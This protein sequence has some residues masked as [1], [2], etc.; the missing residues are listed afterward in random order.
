MIS[1]ATPI[2]RQ[3]ASLRLVLLAVFAVAFVPQAL[4]PVSVAYADAAFCASP[5]RDGTAPTSGIVNAYY[6]PLNLGS[7]SAGTTSIALGTKRPV[8]APN[9]APGDLVIVMQMQ[10]ATFDSTNT[11]AY[12]DGVVLGEASGYTGTPTAGRYE[13]LVAGPATTATSLDL[14]G[15]TLVNTYTQAVPTASQGHQRYQ[16]VRVPQYS[17][18]TLAVAGIDVEDWNGSTGGVLAIDVAGELNFNGARI[19]AEEA[20][21]RG[22]GALQDGHEA[23]EAFVRAGAS[24]DGSKGEG[25]AGTPQFVW[26]LASGSRIDT[27][28]DGYPGGSDARGAP[29]NAGGGGSWIASGG[30]GGGNGGAGGVGG[31]H[32][33]NVTG[34]VNV[35]PSGFGGS[36]IPGTAANIIMGGGGGAGTN[37]DPVPDARASGG[38]GGG[39]VIVR[40]GSV[41][42]TGVIDVNG[43]D[44]FDN[45]SIDPGGGGGAG[46]TVVLTAVSSAGLAN[47][48][49]LA[50]GGDGGDAALLAINDPHGPGGGAA[51]GRVY[52]N[53]ALNAASAVAGGIAGNTQLNGGGFGPNGAT[54]GTAGTIVTNLT[55]ADLPNSVSGAACLPVLTVAKT[56]ST[57]L[58]NLGA[59]AATYAITVSNAAGRGAASAVRLTDPLPAGFTYASGATA[60][61]AGG[62]TGPAAPTNTGSA[63][64]PAFGDFSIPGG[65]SV[66]IGFSV[67]IDASVGAGTYQNPATVTYTDPTRNDPADRATPGS[68]NATG[69]GTTGGSNY[70]SSSSPGEDVTLRPNGQVRGRVFFDLDVNGLRGPAEPLLGGVTITLRDGNGTIIATTTTAADG[71]YLFTSVPPGTF[72]VVV[73]QTD[74]DIPRDTRITAGA[75]NQTVTVVGSSIVQSPDVGFGLTP[76]AVTLAHFGAVRWS[77]G[78]VLVNWV[79]GAERDTYG[80]RV[81]RGTTGDRANA[82][83]VSPL[84]AARGGSGASYQWRDT[85]AGSAAYVYWIEEI[86]VGGTTTVYGPTRVGTAA[87]VRPRIFLPVAI[88]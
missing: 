21:S 65:A 60:T 25:I 55:P 31:T 43:T 73:D 64:V 16:I 59:T 26:S 22:G 54:P 38:A 14:T 86:E 62:A 10:G 75:A 83:A 88:R 81:L 77:D 84:V 12:G 50:T 27:G 23:S 44:G 45:P 34:G 15:T 76:L 33:F 13:Y 5:G 61:F 49:V 8:S 87:A 35:N 18:L 24:Q 72:S 48:T 42:G 66:T 41:A 28:V 36:V 11:A 32:N 71:S 67:A 52:A 78:V 19:N 79:T 82:V 20:G 80:F 63:T 40:T 46:G 4:S 6:P 70:V 57:P 7:V 37:N 17:S 68:P 47:I 53:G 69:G 29:A 58:Q 1:L 56:T 2:T 30:G 85:T 74:P 39:I 9:L 3:N 51:G